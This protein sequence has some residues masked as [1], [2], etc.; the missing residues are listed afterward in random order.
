MAPL[1]RRSTVAV[2]LVLLAA[3]PARAQEDPAQE[4]PAVADTAQAASEARAAAEEWLALVDAGDAGAS[5]ESASS[6]LQNETTPQDW[7]ASLDAVQSQAGDLVER[8]FAATRFQPSIPSNPPG[9]YV[10]VQY[11]ST[12]ANVSAREVVVMRRDD[13]GT[14]RTAGYVVRPQPPQAP[15]HRR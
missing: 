3:V 4:V 7:T 12:Y 6:V 5:Y 1:L 15:G 13:D 10:L 2:L 9:P 14:W 11:T 8:S